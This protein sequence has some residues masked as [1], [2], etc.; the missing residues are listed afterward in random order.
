MHLTRFWKA[1]IVLT[2]AAAAAVTLVSVAGASEPGATPAMSETNIIDP[3]SARGEESPAD[4]SESELHGKSKKHN[5]V[6]TPAVG[7]TAFDST[8]NA[9]TGQ[10]FEGLGMWDQRTLNGFYLE[11]P[12][13]GLCASTDANVGS[14]GR[15]LEA[16][17]DV[18]AVYNTSGTTLKEQTLNRFFGYPDLLT[19]GP[20]LTDPSCYYD[21][22][23]GAWLVVVLTLELGAQG[24]FTG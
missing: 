24:N 3:L 11:P 6:A 7:P 4:R 17:N 1:V 10:S 5:G 8:S 14:G 19:G 23:T 9:I 16:V 13:Q 22:E 2:A 15:V 21:S 12:D 18:V 20:E